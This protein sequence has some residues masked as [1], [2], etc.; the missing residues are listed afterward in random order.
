MSIAQINFTINQDFSKLVSI[1]DDINSRWI[2]N[3]LPKETN[4]ILYSNLINNDYQIDLG[5]L[6]SLH[7]LDGLTDNKK[8]A[9]FLFG[10]IIETNLSCY[11]K[12]KNDF[13][14]LDMGAVGL[15]RTIGNINTHVDINYQTL[16]SEKMC[17]LNYV[18]KE[19]HCDAIFFVG[20][21]S[22]NLTAGTAWL[23][24]VTKLHG[25]RTN[26]LVYLLQLEFNNPYDQVLDWFQRTPNLSY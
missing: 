20:N 3:K 15:F 18:F 19:C 11:K 1:Y 9:S 2:D 7:V 16:K 12:L 21:D 14:E 5:P 22:A 6:G 8:T 10:K 17:K 25:L 24:D 26:G 13:K 23:A 4:L